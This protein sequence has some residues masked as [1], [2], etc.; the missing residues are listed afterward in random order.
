[1]SEELIKLELVTQYDEPPENGN[2]DKWLITQKEL[3]LTEMVDVID[4]HARIGNKKKLLAD[5]VNSERK[6]STAVGEGFAVPHIRSMQAKEFII[7][8]A[9]STNGYDFE[10]PDGL[11]VHH[12][13]IMAAPPYDDNLYLKVFKAVS[14]LVQ[15]GNLGEKLMAAREPYDVIRAIKELE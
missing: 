4:P 3:L 7:A 1:M 6:A 9:R 12:F 13:F 10:S 2:A 11:P 8:F 14:E 15:F 5:F